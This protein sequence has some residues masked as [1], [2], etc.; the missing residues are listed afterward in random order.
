MVAYYTLE[1]YLEY[2]FKKLKL[3]SDIRIY[4][5]VHVHYR[6]ATFKKIILLE[7][8]CVYREIEVLEVNPKTYI[9]LY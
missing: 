2:M 3:I 5:Y 1:K 4:V 9:T 7:R 8:M 6:I